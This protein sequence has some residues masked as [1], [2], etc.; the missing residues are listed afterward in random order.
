M[1]KEPTRESALRTSRHEDSPSS[2]PTRLRTRN[3]HEKPMSPAEIERELNE[4]KGING[5]IIPWI[6][7]ARSTLDH[8]DHGLITIAFRSETDAV[9]F[10]L[11]AYSLEATTATPETTSK[12][13]GSQMLQ[14][15]QIHTPDRSCSLKQGTYI[16]PALNKLRQNTPIMNTR[17]AG[18]IRNAHSN[19]KCVD[20][21]TNHTVND[22]G[23]SVWT[24]R[25]RLLKDVGPTQQKQPPGWRS[26]HAVNLADL[27]KPVK[28]SQKQHK[29]KTNNPR[30]RTTR[31]TETAR[32]Q[33]NSMPER[34]E[35]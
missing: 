20:C 21:D 28:Q 22:P 12:R 16:A 11:S 1:I 4:S 6:L 18:R 35:R 15:P 5:N 26:R 10:K 33:C 29:T 2:H 3:D 30:R 27:P 8:V 31:T 23:R 9:H 24:K 17:N 13:E 14:L 34:T 32:Q 25:G 7:I 19:I